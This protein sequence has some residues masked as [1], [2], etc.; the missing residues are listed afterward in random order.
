MRLL[1]LDP[2]FFVF[3]FIAAIG[4]GIHGVLVVKYSRQHDPLV[5]AA[6]RGLA[7]SIMMVPVLLMSPLQEI[8]GVTDYIGIILGG[9]SLGAAGFAISMTGSR[10]LPIGVAISIRHAMAVILSIIIGAILLQEFLTPVQT[11]LLVG[12]VSS[13]VGVALLRSEHIH[14]DSKKAHIGILC[15]L[16]AGVF[17]STSFYFFSVT[18]RGINPFVAAYF[19]EVA[20]GVF[21]LL[22]LLIL[23]A[24][25]FRNVSFKIPSS[26]LRDICLISVL[27]IFASVSYGFALTHGPYPLA[28]GLMVSMILVGVITAWFLFNERLRK[29]QILCILLTVL[30]IMLIRLV[31]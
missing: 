20:I 18:A 15:S 17:T 4:F 10:H 26:H 22:Y 29:P 1:M 12:L 31:S 3:I 2:L 24:M 14:L 23:G 25:G 9:A 21:S 6:Y 11:V 19:S 7:L 27:T 5:V 28:V 30:F 8:A 16:L 13:V